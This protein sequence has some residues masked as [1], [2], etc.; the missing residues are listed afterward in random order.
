MDLFGINSETE[1]D[2][3]NYQANTTSTL[4]NVLNHIKKYYFSMLLLKPT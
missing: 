1:Y 2:I 3:K 4:L